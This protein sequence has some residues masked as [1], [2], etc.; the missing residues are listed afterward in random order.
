MS[1]RISK[2]RKNVKKNMRQ[3]ETVVYEVPSIKRLD[4][5]Y[6]ESEIGYRPFTTFYEDFSIAELFGREAVIDTCK[7]C[8]EEWKH[9]VKY[10]TELVMIINW[11]SWHHYSEGNEEY[12]ELYSNLYY[13]V[14]NIALE[15]FI[16][17]EL[18]YYYEKTDQEI[19][20]IGT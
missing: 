9:D 6:I 15:T 11:K 16:G 5:D 7:R 19:S 4:R 2:M 10:F 17:E 8:V 13:E 3:V 1:N 14:D 20:D 12:A 18:S